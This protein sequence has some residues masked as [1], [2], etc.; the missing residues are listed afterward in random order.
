[1]DAGERTT[2]TRDEH[3]D[4]VSVLYHALQA[5]DA[6]DRYALDAEVAGDDRLA[7]FF[8]EVQVLNTG[9]AER[10]K[11]LLGI[12]GAAPGTERA[13]TAGY[14]PPGDRPGDVPPRSADVQREP[15]VRGDDVA[16]PPPE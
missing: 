10:T 8:R 4:L 14:V 7:G 15:D 6:C 12:R 9:V 2:G 3:Y 13:P 5:A 16:V 11:D 1:M